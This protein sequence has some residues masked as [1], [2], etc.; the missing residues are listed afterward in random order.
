MNPLF[1][2]QVV[3]AERLLK[4]RGVR[5]IYTGL[6]LSKPSGLKARSFNGL[7]R[8]FANRQSVLTTSKVK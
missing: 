6:E 5:N 1:A 3:D 4:R 2:R 7:I 8:R